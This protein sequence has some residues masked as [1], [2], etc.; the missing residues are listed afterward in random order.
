MV[1]VHA[2]ATGVGLAAW[3]AE[4]GVLAAVGTGGEA[5]GEGWVVA[6]EGLAAWAAA[7]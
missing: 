3:A 2:L 7:G 6:G 1:A 5:L 4:V